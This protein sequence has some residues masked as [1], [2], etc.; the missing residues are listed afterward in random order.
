VY[1]GGH[2]IPW[3]MGQPM[4]PGSTPLMTVNVLITSKRAGCTV[5][6]HQAQNGKTPWVGPFRAPLGPKSVT[7]GR[8]FC[9][10]LLLLSR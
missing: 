2:T 6:T 3:Y 4:L 7:V 1:T 9:A 5:R 10:E 8:D